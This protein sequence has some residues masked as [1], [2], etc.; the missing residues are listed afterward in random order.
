MVIEQ[1]HAP[2]TF[3]TAIQ[4]AEVELINRATKSQDLNN[5]Q[6]V[7]KIPQLIEG[8]RLVKGAVL[9]KHKYELGYL[10]QTD[11]RPEGY[12]VIAPIALLLNLCDGKRNVEQIAGE[13]KDYLS[14][15]GNEAISIVIEAVRNLL[16][17]GLLQLTDN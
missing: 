4:M 11:Q 10:L 14:D 2:D 9:G 6:L 1:G 17:D 8:A 5:Q 13:M 7:E 15:D 16:A 12:P 3:V